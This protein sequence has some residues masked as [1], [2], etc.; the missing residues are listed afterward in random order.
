MTL[1]IVTFDVTGWTEEQVGHLTGE[2]I[3]QGEE[4]D[5]HP[6]AIAKVVTMEDLQSEARANT[7]DEVIDWL[8]LAGE[9][10]TALAMRRA[11]D[12]WPA[13][14]ECELVGSECIN[15]GRRA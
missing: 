14:H 5:D 2:A 3:V 13:N 10:R 6:E 4:S 1:A 7:L 15:C 12:H 9:Q 11:F 8:N